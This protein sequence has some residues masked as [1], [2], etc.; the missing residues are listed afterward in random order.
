MNKENDMKT[1]LLIAAC[2]LMVGCSVSEIKPAQT[3]I[4]RTNADQGPR[5]SL[6]QTFTV[7]IGQTTQP[8]KES[9]R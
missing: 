7:E 2:V 5:K 6:H 9:L 3:A 4:E 8:S 1:L